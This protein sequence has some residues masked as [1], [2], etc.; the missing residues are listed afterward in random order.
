MSNFDYFKQ[1]QS[2]INRI[3][4][5]RREEDNPYHRQHIEEFAAMMDEKI[6]TQVPAMIQQQQQQQQEAQ[7]IKIQ[8]YLNGKHV[9]DGDLG[10]AVKDYLIGG[11]KKTFGKHIKL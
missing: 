1:Y 10:K 2:E 5:M 3:R 6:R 9:K 11:L 4:Q 8:T 7:R